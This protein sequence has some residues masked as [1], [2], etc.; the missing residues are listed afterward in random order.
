MSRFVPT[1]P[2]LVEY[3]ASLARAQRELNA[4]RAVLENLLA[5]EGGRVPIKPTD[6]LFGRYVEVT[7]V[8]TQVVRL[9]ELAWDAVRGGV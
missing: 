1:F 7:E 5:P 9:A 6:P 8:Q 4:A 3:H 2:K